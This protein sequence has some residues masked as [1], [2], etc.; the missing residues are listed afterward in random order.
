MVG[1]ENHAWLI[2][3]DRRIYLV[4]KNGGYKE[5]IGTLSPTETGNQNPVENVY[6]S[7]DG[8][9]LHFTFTSSASFRNMNIAPNITYEKGTY[10]FTA[11]LEYGVISNVEAQ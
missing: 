7:D 4:Y 10:N 3:N 9:F 2:E 6:L 5:L 1:Y 8:K 11:D